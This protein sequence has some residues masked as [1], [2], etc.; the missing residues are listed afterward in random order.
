MGAL[1][2]AAVSAAACGGKEDSRFFGDVSR[3]PA[4]RTTL[5]ING[6]AEPEHLDP[7]LATDNLGQQLAQALFEGLTT[8]HPRDLH[9]V[10]GVACRWERSDDGRSYRFHLRAD[11][12]WSDGRQVVSRDFVYAW[13]RLIRPNTGSG[14]AVDL[15]PL[16]NAER[17]HQS[18][19]RVALRDLELRPPPGGTARAR[20]EK[21]EAVLVIERAKDGEA[22]TLIARYRDVPT[23]AGVPPAPASPPV[24][25]GFVDEADLG[26][27]D[28]LLG[29]RATSDLTLD[30]ELERPTPYFLDLTSR[31]TLAPLREDVVERFAESGYRERWTRPENMVN[32]GPFSLESW[33]FRHA[34]TMKPNPCF[35]ARDTVRL[36]KVEWLEIDS[37]YAAMNLFKAGDLDAFG[38]STTIPLQLRRALA[39][40]LDVRRFSLQMSYWYEINVRARPFDD[41]R[42]RQAFAFAVDRHAL[43]EHVLSGSAEEATHYV[44]EIIGGGYADGLAA[45]RAAG[46]A[47]FAGRAFDPEKAR[48]LLGAAGYPVLRVGDGRRAEGFPAVELLFNGEDGAHRSVAVAIQDMWRREL[49]VTVT[50]R[51]EEWKVMLADVRSGQF[52]IA[53][54]GWVADFNHPHTFLDTFRSTSPHNA[55][56]W[57][58]REFDALIERAS[59]APDPQESLRLYHL[60]ERRA[61]A[62]APRIPLFFST[63]ATLVKPWVK[64]FHGN[65]QGLDL[66][67]WMWIDPEWRAHPDDDPASTP[68][69]LP[70]MGRLAGP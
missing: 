16:K 15:Y 61:L 42:V 9:P 53:R 62:E 57:S 52:Q 35:W 40:K 70:P 10:Q 38:S 65:G 45:E 37:S 18:L 6:V 67:R 60:A 63:G 3:G 26:P 69:E 27:G 7:G 49:G 58:D 68:L 8:P 46:A 34:I 56:G 44:P 43:V 1:C 30:V 13:R 55:T 23:F 17:I 47:P 14:A 29:V 28:A 4:D 54:G 64:G 59:Q 5:T 33:V 21:G 50:L 24:P 36:Q 2:G 12:R 41:A 31:S 19:I 25:L 51:A 66:V 20:L 11:A 39:G 48:A 22:G 32:N